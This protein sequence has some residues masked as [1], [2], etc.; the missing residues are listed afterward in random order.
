MSYSIVPSI[1]MYDS[2]RPNS[3]A[4]RTYRENWRRDFKQRQAFNKTTEKKNCRTTRIV[5]SNKLYPIYQLRTETGKGEILIESKI[6]C[7]YYPSGSSHPGPSRLLYISHNL[8]DPRLAYHE[9]DVLVV[10]VKLIA[11]GQREDERPRVDK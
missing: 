8:A 7:R 11:G 10:T 6:Q 9:V 4:K 5:L 3:I 1:I 2:I